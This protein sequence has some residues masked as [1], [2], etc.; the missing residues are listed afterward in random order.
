MLLYSML[1][2]MTISFIVNRVETLGCLCALVGTSA[3]FK[4]SLRVSRRH[5]SS[6]ITSIIRRL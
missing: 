6:D 2:C 5:R 3:W 1:Q 4:P